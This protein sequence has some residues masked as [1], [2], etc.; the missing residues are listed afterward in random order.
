MA[1]RKRRWVTANGKR[2]EAWVVAY[3]DQVGARHIRTF[4]KRSKAKTFHAAVRSGDRPKSSWDDLDDT[5]FV[6]A[7]MRMMRSDT[8]GEAIFLCEQSAKN[9]GSAAQCAA[10]LRKRL[11]QTMAAEG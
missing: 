10:V 8:L 7:I 9:G 6:T 5:Y 1:I 2:R 4:S 11:N 3:S